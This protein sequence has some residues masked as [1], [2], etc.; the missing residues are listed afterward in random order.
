M[1]HITLQ[2]EEEKSVGLVQ[3]EL[4]YVALKAPK[5]ERNFSQCLQ[6]LA[7]KL[8]SSSLTKLSK[9]LHRDTRVYF[10]I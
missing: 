10:L 4:N 6:K 9:E 1:V 3:K 8:S 2:E 7:P 5:H